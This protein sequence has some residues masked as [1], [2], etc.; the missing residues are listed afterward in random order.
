M[1]R[2]PTEPDN[3]WND[4]IS[5]PWAAKA[6]ATTAG[7]ALRSFVPEHVLPAVQELMGTGIRQAFLAGSA[8]TPRL[9]G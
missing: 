9:V 2:L 8:V 7:G 3:W 5:T 1:G 6:L 4:A